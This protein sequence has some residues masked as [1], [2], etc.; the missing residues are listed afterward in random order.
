M[1]ISESESED[2]QISKLEQ[3]EERFL[4]L[5]S[6]V[7]PRS[8]KGRMGKDKED[9][10]APCSMA[11]LETCRLTRDDIVKHYVKP[12]F[13]DFV[14]GA[15]V[16]YLIGQETDGS[17]VYR[18]CQINNLAPDFVKPYKVNDKTMNQAFELRHG[19]S[20]KVF[21]MDKVSNGPF[22]E[23][24]FERLTKTCSNEDVKLPSKRTAENKVAQM[25]KL[26]TQPMTESDITAMLA[27]KSQLQI[28]SK[29]TGMTT[30][31]R[32]RLN[33]ARTLAHRRNDWNEVAEIDAKL[34]EEAA[35][36][37]G[38][39]QPS[40]TNNVQD[41][42]AKV[43]ERNRKANMDAVRKAEM[44]EME[45]KKKGRKLLAQSTP[46][47]PSARL[48]TLPR[49][50]NSNTP[51]TRPGTPATPTAAPVPASKNSSFEA[52]LIESVEIDLG[53]F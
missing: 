47:D 37:S 30:M 13:Q 52:Y 15:W 38:K 12:W 24:E 4:N 48:K 1:D 39:E 6:G 42:L 20:L 25:Q 31:E 51:L 16:R 8:G 18:I 27:R 46:V 7:D 21:M 41:L 53:D 14:T 43:N 10:D 3:E 32:S 22:L 29:P 33:Q 2:G 9:L 11:D 28:S 40:K 34:A 5:T 17:P 49:T 44:A 35:R 19:R 23:K 26:V 50:F 45:R 36:T